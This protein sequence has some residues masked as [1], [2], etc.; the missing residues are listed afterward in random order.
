V[1][2]VKVLENDTMTTDADG[3]PA[4]SVMAV[5]QGGDD[6][7]IAEMIH[8]TKAGGMQAYGNVQRT[9]IDSQGVPQ[10]IGFSRPQ[11]V[12]IYITI[13]VTKK[14]GETVTE[15]AVKDALIAYGTTL[16]VGDSVVVYPAMVAALSA[17][18]IVDVVIKVGT[19]VSPTAD[20]NITIT[21]SQQAVFDV[22]RIGVTIL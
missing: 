13:T 18:P 2:S 17:L 19:T 3:L 22:S 9:V 21:Q 4:K 20:D 16:Q 12:P 15:Q 11:G 7:A 5:V 8:K 6:D 14:S 10:T 1:T